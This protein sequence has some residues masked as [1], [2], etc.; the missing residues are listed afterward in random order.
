MLRPARF[1]LPNGIATDGERFSARASN[2]R[3]RRGRSRFLM[4]ATVQRAA[5]ANQPRIVGPLA[6]ARR[7]CR[8]TGQDRRLSWGLFPFSVSQRRC[9]IRVCRTPDNPAST[10]REPLEADRCRPD[11]SIAFASPRPCGFSPDLRAV[12]SATWCDHRIACQLV[13]HRPLAAAEHSPE[14]SFA[15]VRRSSSADRH[16]SAPPGVPLAL[17]T[18]R[19]WDFTLRSFAP[20]GQFRQRIVRTGEGPPVVSP[21]W[22]IHL[23]DFVRGIGRSLES[24]STLSRPHSLRPIRMWRVRFL[25]FDPSAPAVR[26]PCR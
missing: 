25:G 4:R 22:H 21:H 14:R 18:Q 20:A 1:S 9:A 8:R 2:L 11:S 26:R 24:F 12:T 10:L 5:A 3:S 16:E 23:D 7:I 17:R 13:A 15:F 6:L 19:S